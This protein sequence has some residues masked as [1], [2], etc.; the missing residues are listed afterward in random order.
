MSSEEGPVAW[1][2]AAIL[3]RK[4]AAGAATPGPWEFEGD[5]P[6]D[7]ELFS[8]HV[9]EHGDLVG[10]VVAFTRDRQVANGQHMALNDPQD[11]IARCEAELAILDEHYILYRDDTNELYEEFSVCYPPGIPG[12][13]CGCVTCHYIGHGG[14]KEYG[15]CRTVKLLAS[16]YRR[17]PGYRE[18]DWKPGVKLA[19]APSGRQG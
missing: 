13:N 10:D 6:T 4:A 16:A 8:A 12:M 7:D 19:K 17:R 14:V 18:E 5:D 11:T 9:G 15:I 2:R 1:L 3:A